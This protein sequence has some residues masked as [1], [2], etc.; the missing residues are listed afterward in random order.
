MEINKRCISAFANNAPFVALATKSKLFDPT[1]SLTSELILINYMT[2]KIYPPVTT[3]LKFC[4]ILWCE[5][6]DLS[7]LVAGHEN[8]A[9]SIYDLRE[10]GLVL[11]KMKSYIDGDVNALDFLP[12]KA[13]L[14]AGSSRGKI[15]FWTLTNLEK[16][17]VL[18]IPLSLDISAISWNPKVSKILC[19]GSK[20]GVIKVLDIKKNTVLTTLGN[21]DISEVKNLEWDSENNTKLIVMGEKGYLVEFDLTNDFISKRGSHTEP[22]IGFYQDILVSKNLIENKGHFI[23]IPESFDCSISRRDPVIGLSHTSGVTKII[24]IPY[25]K[26]NVPIFR[27]RNY[28]FGI[29]ELFKINLVNEKN[30]TEENDFYPKLIKFLFSDEKAEIKSI[31]E[32]LIDNA[33]SSALEEDGI[34]VDLE[35]PFTLEIIRGDISNLAR[36]DINIPLKLLDSIL[37]KNLAIL[38]EITDFNVLFI[39]SKLLNN[40]KYLSKVKN[41]RVLAA[42][43]IFNNINDFSFLSGSK[44]AL[45]LRGLFTKNLGEYLDNACN[46]DSP[47]LTL[48]P[49][50][51]FYYKQVESICT[52]PLDSKFLAE[53]FWYKVMLNQVEDVKN[54]KITDKDVNFF[55]RMNYA[56]PSDFV[57]KIKNL[58]TSKTGKEIKSGASAGEVITTAGNAPQKMPFSSKPSASG[59]SVPYSRP[60]SYS[61][62][63]AGSGMRGAV[64]LN[65]PQ[66]SG[67]FIPQK[68]SFSPLQPGQ[69]A[70]SS[71]SSQPFIPQQPSQ[72][73]VPQQPSQPFI[74]KTTPHPGFSTP[75]QPT[76]PNP[77]TFKSFTPPASK[78]PGTLPFRGA[79]QKSPEASNIPKAFGNPSSSIPSPSATPFQGFPSRN[80]SPVMQIRNVTPSIPLSNQNAPSRP[81]AGSMGMPQE[82]ASSSLDTNN[83]SEIVKNF[84]IAVEDLKAKAEGITSF[85]HRPRKIQYLNSLNVFNTIDV[86][87]LRPEVLYTMDLLCKRLNSKDSQMKNDLDIIIRDYD[88]GDYVWLKAFV[89]LAKMVY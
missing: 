11:L 87:G 22:L 31:G 35:D 45:L 49:Q 29:G 39:M 37:N 40:F 23:N 74:P 16:E 10:E 67:A 73:F 59:Y 89:E 57:E 63:I 14:V 28:I 17:Y 34:D 84:N 64:S 13:V 56:I 12:S 65:P 8:G 43:I 44:E 70:N 83:S 50:I 4:K 58:N 75:A 62:P 81:F 15:I 30:F 42:L 26:K 9:I 52:E 48:M 47:Y 32:F 1:F 80:P 82:R 66:A 24:S 71:Q 69:I 86:Q 53:F 3:E 88:S 6:K 85:I 41:A 7:Y 27:H 76:V 68:P 51:E 2:G 38:D 36:S 54:L 33:G 60:S 46:Y 77:S 78:I 55:I 25:V 21:K 18:D 19:I 79:F 20:D 61:Q 5:C 72:S